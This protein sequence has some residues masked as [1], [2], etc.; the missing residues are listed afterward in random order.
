MKIQNSMKIC[1]FILYSFFLMF[2]G[3]F[4]YKYKTC[5]AFNIDPPLEAEYLINDV[6]SENFVFNVFR[7]GKINIPYKNLGANQSNLYLIDRILAY[8]K[9]S[10]VV[11]RDKNGAYNIYLSHSGKDIFL[12]SL[13]QFI[14][15]SI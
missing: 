12:N 8:N 11:S 7:Y 1:F 9:I 2:V 15:S 3:A 4:L 6:H 5:I 14:F 13:F 10:Y